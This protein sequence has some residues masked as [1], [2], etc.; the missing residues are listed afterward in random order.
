MGKTV[1]EIVGGLEIVAG[2]ALANPGLIVSGALTLGSAVLAPTLP[3]PSLP[4]TAIK[5]PTPVRRSGYGVG[6]MLPTWTLYEVAPNGWAVDCYAF[7]DGRVNKIID[8]YIGDRRV[9]LL[10]GGYVQELDGSAFKGSNNCI[11]GNTMG[12]PTETAFSQVISII[13]DHWTT[14]HRGDGVVTGFMLSK[15]VKSKNWQTVYS[16]GGPNQAP[17]S[18]SMERQLVYDWRDPD[19]VASDPSTHKYSE[20]FILHLAHYL[21]YR[22]DTAPPR[23]TSSMTPDDIAAAQAAYTARLDA[24]W[25][26]KFAPTIDAWTAA[27]DDADTPM[28]LNGVQTILAGKAD[29]GDT[30]VNVYSTNGLSAGME[31]AIAISGDTSKTE[32]RTVTSI[33]GAFVHF[34]GGLSYD[35]PQSSQVT[36]SSD[37][38]S[39]A[40]EPRYR[41]CVT[42]NHSDA[43]KDTINA[44]L[45]CGDGMLATRADGAYL[46]YSGRFTEPTIPTVGPRDILS[47]SLQYGVNEE[48]SVN[49]LKVTYVSM[50]H[51]FNVVDTDDWVDE[52]RLDQDGKENSDSFAVQSPSFSQNRRLAKRAM[53]KRNAPY[54][55]QVVISGRRRDVQGQRYIPLDL[56]EAGTA[57]FSG[58]VELSN[59]K[60]IMAS[61]AFQYDFVAVDASIDG[62]IPALEEGSPAPVGN[63][64]AVQPL[65]APTITLATVEYGAQAGDG[66]TGTYLALTVTSPLA[67]R[68]DITWYVQ[69]RQTGASVWGERTLSDIP[70]GSPAMLISE[71][72]PTNTSVDVQVAYGA[73]DG[74][75][76]DFSPI[77]TVDTSTDLTAPDAA[78]LPTLLSWTDSFNLT[79]PVIPRARIYRW[80]LYDTAGTPNLVASIDTTTNSLSYSA[81][82]AALDGVQRAYN[83]KVSGVN[84]AGEGTA[85]ITTTPFTKP[86]PAA[87]TTPAIA[88]GATTAVA[89]CDALAGAKGYA[90]FYFD[91]SGFD[92]TTEG[93]V[94]TSGTPSINIYGLAADTYYGHIAAFDEWTSN[95]ALL[96]LSSEIS[97]T[98]TT[99]GGSTPSGGGTAGGGYGGVR[100]GGG[101][102]G[103]IP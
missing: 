29:E 85:A 40:T 22:K 97:F 18:L 98:I 77:V 48:D 68:E 1:S 42:H 33:D 74:R 91:T 24:V 27:A 43:H 95:P 23:L 51:D 26:M 14:N 54:R 63:R 59:G 57:F 94:V 71:F 72:V 81:A 37:P 69:T 96:N 36:W 75:L 70:A 38:D 41:G 82:Q 89:T 47:Y 20:N 8:H 2:I 9:S 15:N 11:V 56:T 3:K 76:S 17:L 4:E 67:D 93:G 80:R 19:Q 60:R 7:H 55:G 5:S 87:V 78:T 62:W 39:P 21:L 31:I 84:T 86:A 49:T 25:A 45:A 65:D 53:T 64:V 79:T 32:T 30:Q 34:S 90:A 13:P 58:T 50:N 99:G 83:V 103:A 16:L 28:P 12:L 35:H 6:R 102:G 46:V 61:G 66:A 101:Q 10:A 73:G 92:P 44:I 100:G 88:G 52:D